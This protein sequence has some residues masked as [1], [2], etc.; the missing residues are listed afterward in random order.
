MTP[1]PETQVVETLLRQVLRVP[2]TTQA[3][4]VFGDSRFCMTLTAFDALRMA[5]LPEDVLEFQIVWPISLNRKKV[6]KT[7]PMLALVGHLGL[8][9]GTVT[10]LNEQ[11]LDTTSQG[12]TSRWMAYYVAC[13]EMQQGER[14]SQAP[15]PASFWLTTLKVSS[16][17]VPWQPGVTSTLPL[18]RKATSLKDWT[19]PSQRR[20]RPIWTG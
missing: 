16:R 12:M 18:M 11:R 5:L 17:L 19:I 8:V 7:T 13:H 2:N 20:C 1:I 9:A 14:L 10:Y 3:T 6:G 4:E 15:E